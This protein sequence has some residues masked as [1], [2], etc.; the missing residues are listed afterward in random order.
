MLVLGRP[1]H[2]VLLVV[3]P[4]EPVWTAEGSLDMCDHPLSTEVRLTALELASGMPNTCAGST[5][6]LFCRENPTLSASA[7]GLGRGMLRL[8]TLREARFLSSSGMP[9]IGSSERTGEPG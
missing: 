5:L 9:M 6:S 8:L 1:F 3:Y 2:T 7:R 4:L